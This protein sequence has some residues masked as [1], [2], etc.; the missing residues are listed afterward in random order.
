M[1]PSRYNKKN[2][3]NAVEDPSLVINE[4]KRITRVPREIPRRTLFRMR[5]GPGVNIMEYDWD[6]LFLLDA[7]RYD[8][9]REFV[10]IDGE[11]DYIISQGS[12][13]K[14]FCNANFAGETFYDTVYVTANGYGAQIGKG[15]FHDLLFT[16]EDD[17]VTDVDVLHSTAEGMAPSTVYNAALES[18]NKYQNKRMIV[19]FMQPH[20][21]YLGRRAERLR[22]RVENEGVVIRA[23]DPEKI[24]KYSTNQEKVFNTLAGAAKKGHIT[25]S[26]LREVYIENLE[27]VM[28]YVKS[29]LREVEGKAVITADHGEY[30]GK[31]GK[32]GHPKYEYTEELRKVPWMVVDSDSRP[33][34]EEET[35][36]EPTTVS[37]DAIEKRLKNLGYKD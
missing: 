34:I 23:R 4:V 20:D 26:E 15:V 29:L 30:L 36:V 27:I 1:F 33:D 37:N 12:H 24:D 9:F 6:Y 35:P 32:I 13:S 25:I 3:L 19:H 10:S 17:A 31:N 16:D 5:F 28:K 2:L 8:V 14:E 18:Y 21:P 7:C 11:L 22:D